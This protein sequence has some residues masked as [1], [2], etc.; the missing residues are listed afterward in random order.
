[1]LESLSDNDCDEVVVFAR[2]GSTMVQTLLTELGFRPSTQNAVTDDAS[3]I[4]YAVEPRVLLDRLGI[5]G[6]T[7]G[8]VLALRVD[9]PTVT[10]LGTFHLTLDAAAWPHLH[11]RPEWAEVLTGLS[12]WGFY[13]IDGG[14]NT[15]SPDPSIRPQ[16]VVNP[17]DG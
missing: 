11:G 7:E 16:D 3:F 10:R 9:A 8:D 1:L 17:A 12:G 13:P 4:A 5:A 2:E 6:M 15:P 14:I